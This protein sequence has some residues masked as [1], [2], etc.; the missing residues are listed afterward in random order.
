MNMQARATVKPVLALVLLLS[1]ALGPAMRLAAS[2]PVPALAPAAPAIHLDRN[3]GQLPLYFVENRG[4]L[5]EQVAYY[6][7]GAD[8]SIYFTPSGVT[9]ELNR[10]AV[11]LGEDAHDRLD[12][13]NLPARWA[14]K[15]D[16]IG[17]NPDVRPV[18]DDRAEAVF[19]YF[20]GRPEDW[21]AG[22]RTYRRLTYPELWPGID[23]V[24][25]G[26]VNHMKYEFIVKPGADPA[27]IR[28]AYRGA[29]EVGVNAAGQM[30]VSTPLGAF[31][32]DTP[33]AYQ[34]FA[35]QRVPV[36]MA[37][38]LE[39]QAPDPALNRQVVGEPGAAHTFGFS[40]GHYDP[41]R[42]LVLDPA[43]LLYSGFIGGAN[44]EQA[45][46][47]A[48]DAAGNA[49]VTGGT[50]AVTTTTN[51]PEVVGPDLTHNGG[52]D[53]FVAK[54]NPAGTALVYAGFIGGAGSDRGFGIAVD[55]EG[56]A[57]VTGETDS[58]PATF[59]KVGGPSL[60]FNGS[61][62]AFVAKINPAGTALD[63]AG[64]IGGGDFDVGRGIAVDGAGNAYVTGYTQSEQTLFPKTGGPGLIYGGLGDAFVA[65]VNPTGT[66]LI[67]AGYIGGTSQDYGS[68]IAVDSAGHAY[69]AG[70][71]YAYTTT[72]TFPEVVGPDLTHNG[73]F[74]AFVAKVNPAGTSLVYA[75][76]VGGAGYDWGNGIAVDRDGNAYVTGY[77]KSDQT[78]FPAVVGPDLSFNGNFDAFLAK[79]NPAG[80]NLIYAGYIGGANQD[81][82]NAIAVDGAG[83]AYVTGATNSYTATLPVVVG[84]DLTHNGA[85]DAIVAKVNPAGTALVYAGFIGGA[86]NDRGQGIALDWS[87]NAYVVGET[88]SDQ[89]TFPVV[90]G[91]DLDP[92]GKVDA[93]VA[94]VSANQLFLPLLTR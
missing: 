81:Y 71:T 17:A 90:G 66:A 87:G 16:F 91:P 65:K 13:M 40:V 64:Y 62:D 73:N 86:N 83:N 51:F 94:K 89:S 20:T 19:S 33:V 6:I 69:V 74:D 63:Y 76:F 75:G 34:E 32:D 22:L 59:P 15:L 92:N 7:Q 12:A 36:S 9:F 68:A 80:T 26:S 31:N 67:Y 56:D 25:S 93:F 53:A 47:I 88:S 42:P 2:S 54:I 77:T 48:V 27:R 70:A 4:Q 21:K 37:F 29:T 85:N 23:L 44:E 28:L 61:T 82:G 78:T 43:V 38:A 49:F 41:T 45:W 84:P 14:V 58:S 46:G 3:F 24:Y 39:R 35:G 50:Y 30:Q 72:T 55:G 5:D 60:T 11:K 10:G 18:A 1:L 57:F 79:V 8:K 52:L